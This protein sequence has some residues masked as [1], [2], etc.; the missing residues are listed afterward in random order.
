M[1]PRLISIAGPHQGTT[2]PIATD[3]QSIG[4]DSTNWISVAGRA[5]SRKHCAIKQSDGKF[6]IV[7][8]DSKNGTSINGIPIRERFL[9]EGDRIEVGDSVF[10][11]AISPEQSP[12]IKTV[13]DNGP[14]A[15][16][17]TRLR[18]DDVL[19]LEPERLLSSVPLTARIAKGLDALLKLSRAIQAV[20]NLETLQQ[21]I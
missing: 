11:F 10:I 13:S 7:D 4:R 19:Y 1:N 8:L 2:F 17:T 12:P 15:I 5:V 21:K 20:H 6:R 18:L 16:P 9:E 3:E 14:A